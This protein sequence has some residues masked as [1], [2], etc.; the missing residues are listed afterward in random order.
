MTISTLD[1]I[2]FENLNKVP[3]ESLNVIDDIGN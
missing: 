1:F 2:D 3:A